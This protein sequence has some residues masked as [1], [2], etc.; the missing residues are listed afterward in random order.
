MVPRRKGKI[1]RTCRGSDDAVRGI[2][3]KGPR[4]FVQR[5]NDGY[6]ERE[7]SDD[8]RSRSLKKPGL[9]RDLQMEAASR[10]EHLRLP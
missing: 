7:Q 9:E 3:V 8:C 2:A 4:E 5:E 6:V 1:A 10:M